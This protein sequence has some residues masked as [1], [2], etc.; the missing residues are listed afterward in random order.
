MSQALFTCL[1]LFIRK[2]QRAA[3][4]QQ[5]LALNCVVGM[6]PSIELGLPT[7]WRSESLETKPLKLKT[8]ILQPKYNLCS[9]IVSWV[10]GV[11]T[12]QRAF[13]RCE[14][15]GEPSALLLLQVRDLTEAPIQHCPHAKRQQRIDS[16]LKGQVAWQRTTQI[17]LGPLHLATSRYF[18]YLLRKRTSSQCW[19]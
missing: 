10:T 13:L 8:L 15:V 12:E 18:N 19:R 6:G 5:I 7:H 14:W 3:S 4:D 11:S 16:V 2:R 1:S 9:G 17:N